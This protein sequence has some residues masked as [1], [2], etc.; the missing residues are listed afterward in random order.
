MAD[1]VD[2]SLDDIIKM[3]KKSKQQQQYKNNSVGRRTNN[4][5]QTNVVRNNFKQTRRTN[6][7]SRVCIFKT[8]I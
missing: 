3:N 2:M 7:Y 8:K 5:R 6:P 1:K 4:N